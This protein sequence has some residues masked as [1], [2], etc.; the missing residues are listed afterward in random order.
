[1][2]IQDIKVPQTAEGKIE[3]L[4]EHALIIARNWNAVPVTYYPHGYNLDQDNGWWRMDD[5]TN[6]VNIIESFRED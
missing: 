6:A 2:V 5:L 3:R 1:M 4:N